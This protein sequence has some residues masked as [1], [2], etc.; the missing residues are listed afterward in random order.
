ML[1][2][3]PLGRRFGP[4]HDRLGVDLGSLGHEGLLGEGGHVFVSGNGCFQSVGLVDG[5]V[6]L[7]EQIA[8]DLLPV[9]IAVE[10]R[11]SLHK[12]KLRLVESPERRQVL[13]VERRE[14]SLVRPD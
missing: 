3:A 9:A 2:R 4:H 10:L 1:G 14:F 12:T 6:R 8:G 11:D 7:V 13:A 5:G